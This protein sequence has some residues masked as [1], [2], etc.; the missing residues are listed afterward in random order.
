LSIRLLR[1]DHRDASQ[2]IRADGSLDSA[3]KSA[4]AYF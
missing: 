3:E 4:K 1:Y 2:L